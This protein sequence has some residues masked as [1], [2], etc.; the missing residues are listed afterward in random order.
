MDM[1]GNVPLIMIYIGIGL[2]IK[3]KVVMLFA[4]RNNFQKI[5]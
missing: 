3:V 5:L 2:E 1:L 4:V